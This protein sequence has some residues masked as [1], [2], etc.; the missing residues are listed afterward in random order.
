MTRW[1]LFLVVDVFDLDELVVRS[2]DR[3][4]CNYTLLVF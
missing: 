1:R 2:A 4:V 3:F